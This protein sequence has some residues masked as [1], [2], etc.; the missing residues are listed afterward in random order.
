MGRWLD[1]C[2]D[3]GL[4]LEFFWLG[5]DAEEFVASSQGEPILARPFFNTD[6]GVNGEDAQLVA[7]DDP[8]AGDVLDGTVRVD[9][10]AEAYSLATS[11]HRLLS[12]NY[13][14]DRGY[15]V[16]LVGGYRFFRLNESLRISESLLVT[17]AGGLVAQ[18]TTLDLFDD[19]GA[20][21]EFHGGEIGLRTVICRS[22]WSL[23]VLAKLGIGNNHQHIRINGQNSVVVPDFAPFTSG[24]GLFAQSSNFGNYENDEVALL[25]EFQLNVAWQWTDFTRLRI[26]Y[27][28]LFLTEAVRPGGHID[29]MVNGLFLDPLAP[30]FVSANPAFAFDSTS[31]WMQ[32]IN[33]GIERVW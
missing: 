14:G 25:P 8:V 11:F 6:P 29:R 4:G 16:H 32:G 2:Q 24:G 28:L 13:C 27:T 31:V 19:F 1:D 26:G 20:S 7:F 21:N 9:T 15:Q 23:D 12:S 5:D 3:V 10:S 17:E 18:G 30:P 33:L 22:A